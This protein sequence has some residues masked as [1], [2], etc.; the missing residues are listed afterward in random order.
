MGWGRKGGDS[1]AATACE[2]AAFPYSTFDLPGYVHSIRCLAAFIRHKLGH[3]AG[4]AEYDGY[5]PVRIR[6]SD[7]VVVLDG[8]P[9]W[10]LFDRGQ[11]L[12]VADA[13]DAGDSKE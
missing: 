4:Q 1:R 7:D 8:T 5:V 13:G 10:N 11:G 3:P 12:E 9:V 6:D 2:S